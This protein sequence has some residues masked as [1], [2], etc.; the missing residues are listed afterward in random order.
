MAT[1]SIGRVRALLARDNFFAR[2]WYCP[3]PDCD[4]RPHKGYPHPHARASQHPPMDPWNTWFIMAGR[5]W[6]KTRTAAELV[7]YWTDTPGQMVAAV[8]RTATTV[9]E[10]CFEHRFSGLLKIL[11]PEEVA[12]YRRGQGPGETRIVRTNGSVIYGFSAAEPDV[13]RGWAF[14]KVWCEEF[15]N[16]VPSRAQESYDMLR[17]CLRESKDPRTVISTTPKALPHVRK[18]V[19]AKPGSGVVITTG[20]THD[21]APNLSEDA[22]RDLYDDYAGTRMGRQ[23]LYGELLE[24][25]E[26]ALWSSAIF[27]AEGFRAAPA[28]RRDYDRI[29]IGVDPAVSDSENADLTGI[30]VAAREPGKPYPLGEDVAQG[31]VLHAEQQRAT[32]RAAMGRVAELAHRYGADMVVLESN[33]GG[34]YLQTVLRMVD[35]TVMSR[36][37]NATRGKRSRATPVA[38]LY[39]QGR[40]HHV[41]PAAAFQELEEQ[42]MA[43]TGAD[44]EKSP[45]LLDACVW[46]LHDL[47]LDPT[48]AGTGRIHYDI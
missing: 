32:P 33:N 48:I 20:A 21:N 24:D 11:P 14:D 23:E 1:L 6:G 8:A 38:T 40:I 26:G 35:P 45:D 18:L 34:D 37:V 4:G 30:V 15:A 3:V 29:V 43:Y 31:Y 41:G 7:K 16:W 27:E 5:G 42:M 46:A 36:L 22:L 19:N 44:R 10:N 17:F 28:T 9:K 13:L 25:V 2:R 39:E 12:E 47:F